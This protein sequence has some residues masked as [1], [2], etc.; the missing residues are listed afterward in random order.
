RAAARQAE[1]SRARNFFFI[2]ITSFSFS[3]V[4]VM[5]LFYPF[6]RR[7]CVACATKQGLFWGVR[8]EKLPCPEGARELVGRAR[9]SG[10]LPQ[11]VEVAVL[12]GGHEL[13]AGGHGKDGLGL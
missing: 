4:A 9:K 2:V 1:R 8:A 7:I 13:V 5:P 12:I 6:A 3:P 10:F 11:A